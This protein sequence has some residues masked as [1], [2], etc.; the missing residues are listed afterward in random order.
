MKSIKMVLLGTIILVSC[1]SAQSV[2][3]TTTTT[4]IRPKPT[5]VAPI[6]YGS[7]CKR[8]TEMEFGRLFA[9]A[10]ARKQSFLVDKESPS[11]RNI[12]SVMDAHR[13]WRSFIRNLDVPLLSTEQRN[14]VDAIQDYVDALNR[15][16]ESDR[17]DLSLNDYLI[18][19]DDAEKDFDKAFGDICM[20]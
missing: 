13:A 4:T 16:L 9:I 2:P 8:I 19:L 20:R 11:E 10:M 12:Y 14:L 6:D 1:S 3:T 18:P 15:Y 17:K 7:D 5:T